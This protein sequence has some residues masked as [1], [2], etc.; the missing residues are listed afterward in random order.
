MDS[1]ES[2]KEQFYPKD[3]VKEARAKLRHL[4]HK[5]GHLHEYVREF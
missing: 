3:A 5:E 1:R 2:S 4:Q